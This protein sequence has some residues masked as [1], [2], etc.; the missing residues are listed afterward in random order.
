MQ[1]VC[2]ELKFV[3]SETLFA[4]G[5]DVLGL[6]LSCLHYVKMCAMVDAL[7]PLLVSYFNNY[8]KQ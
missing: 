3:I 4:Q 1:Y 7:K 2:H 6:L 5:K 8:G